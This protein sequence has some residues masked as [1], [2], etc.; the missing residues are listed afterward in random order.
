MYVCMH[1]LS[2]QTITS[3][4]YNNNNNIILSP[5]FILLHHPHHCTVLSII[6]TQYLHLMV[7]LYDGLSYYIISP[8]VYNVLRIFIEQYPKHTYEIIC[9]I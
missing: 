1:H 6:H 8:H 7:R 5:P 3:G 9:S 2:I 4:A